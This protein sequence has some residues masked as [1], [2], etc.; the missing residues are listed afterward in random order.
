LQIENMKNKLFFPIFFLSIYIFYTT[1]Q[2][3]GR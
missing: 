1:S 3:L 2:F